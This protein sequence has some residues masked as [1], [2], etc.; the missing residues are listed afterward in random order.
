MSLAGNVVARTGHWISPR[1][2]L[3]T[4]PTQQNVAIVI[5][6]TMFQFN[7]NGKC[8]IWQRQW[9][10]ISPWRL[11]LTGPTQ[12]QSVAMEMAMA[13]FQLNDIGNGKSVWYGIGND[14]AS[15]PGD[16]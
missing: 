11:L 3:L 15:A 8:L 16:C 4:G 14:F 12:R 9:F 10:W 7:G 13:M 6:M 2:L 1:R 5:L